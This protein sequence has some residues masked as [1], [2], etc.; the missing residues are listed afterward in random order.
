MTWIILGLLLLLALWV[1]AGLLLLARGSRR[2]GSDYQREVARR[3][4]AVGE[5]VEVALR[6]VAPVR[7][8]LADDHDV[9]LVID[10]SGSMG[11]GPGSPLREAV[12]AAENFIRRLPDN[13]HVGIIGFDHDARLL[14]PLTGEQ[15]QAMRAL[16]SL[17]AGGGTAIHAA[18]KASHAAFQ[19]GRPGIMKTVILLSDGSSASGPAEAEAAHLRQEIER[20]TLV[21]IGF[22]PHVNE[23]LMRSIA[24]AP[25][26]YLHVNNADDLYGLFSFLAGAV[27]GQMAVAGL[28]DEG[29][30]SPSPFK[31][32]RTGGLY[33][34][35]VQPGDPTRNSATRVVWSI[36][37]MNEA[38]VPLTYNLVAECPGWFPVATDDGKATW[39]LPDGTKTEVR[40]PSGPHVLVM[41]RW[42]GW[43]WPILNPLFWIIFGRFWPCAVKPRESQAAAEPEQLPVAALPAL[44][45]AP[46]QRIYE[47]SLR[48]AL[49]I[50]LGE[51]G[52][53][54]VCRLKERLEDRCIDP[55]QVEALAIHVT[56][57]SNRAPVKVGR[58]ALET[59]EIVELHQDL[60]PYLETLRDEGTPP[61]RNWV[62]W[63]SWLAE[64]PPL[65]TLRT[66]ADD[67]R[68]ARLAL[69]RKPDQVETM[70]D[71]GLRRVV[72]QEGVVIVVGSPAD[73]ECSGLLAEVA[74]ICASRD[75]GV[76][77]L[78][79]PTSFFEQPTT[80]MLALA[81]ELERMSLMKGRNLSSDRHQ[82]PV[83]ARQLFDRIVALEEKYDTPAAASVPAAELIWEML[84]YKEV[85]KQLPLLRADGDEVICCSAAVDSH[86]LPA[87]AL[88]R[89]TRER[90]LALGLNGRRLG[91]TQEQGR[92]V[93]PV[94]DKQTVNDDVDDFW[95]G[96]TSLR[97]QPLLLTRLRP[98]LRST[99][100]D[101]ISALLSLQDAVPFDQPYHEQVAYSRQ[102]RQAFAA[103]LEGWCQHI[104]D[105]EQAQ[106]VWGVHVVMPALL[107]VGDELQVVSN[108]INR[109]SGNVDFANLINFASALLVDFSAIVSDLQ[110]EMAQWI[111]KLVGPQLELRVGSPS[112]ATATPLA[113]SIEEERQALE[114]VFD[115]L[116]ARGQE[117]LTQQFQDWYRSY[118]DLILG[119]LSFRAVREANGERV[120]I[121]LSY[122][123]QELDANTDVAETLR[124][125]LDRYRNVVL[126]WPVEQLAQR[127]EVAN[128]LDR[129]RVGKHSALVYPEVLSVADEEDPF[130]ASAVEVRA[131][132]IRQLLGVVPP[133][134]GDAPY[135]WPEEA[136]AARIAQKIRNRL[137]RDPQ[138]FSPIAV[139][140]M[141]DTEKLHGFIND[142]AQGRVV[143]Q[144]TKYV[145]RRDGH[146]YQV[147]PRDE[148]LQGLDAF[149][150]VVQ[151]VVSDEL[152]LDGQTI[153]PA[154]ADL[155]NS[156]AE[157]LK[158][159]EAH[160]LIKPS[161]KSPNWKMWQDL[162]RGLMLEHGGR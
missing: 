55:A 115:S 145:L 109:L 52:E 159:V 114:S 59:D 34:L 156:L 68:K 146:N 123:Q 148:S 77:A 80:E 117:F 151:Q 113:Y 20:L 120:S 98:A 31:L 119:Q 106:G 150:S 67:R 112:D 142:L 94:A 19:I 6:L 79:A 58:T 4:C 57:R 2:L 71:P 28:V 160:P 63:R 10:H 61:L 73:A 33:P 15:R 139:H 25:D 70:L 90:T 21:C 26:K 108:S 136:N 97:P 11:S 125:A 101:S 49:V 111:A 53:W 40:A 122:S 74:H 43:A 29:V 78:F 72:G 30:S 54:T 5:E 91:L 86:S 45:P 118:G 38:P 126:G 143:Q 36:P 138:P 48:P 137:R 24:S 44:P 103:Y 56:H 83:A 37:L 155:T 81:Q 3:V 135:A 23:S 141:R 93:L 124:T 110:R 1:G 152:S 158:A 105:R 116:D 9:L 161:V 64:M 66:I 89:W 7:M 42:F 50:G 130:V 144:G 16:G 121:R 85:F 87:A 60:R 46:Q 47:P 39:R 154:P 100:A 127:K 157:T 147:G 140:L 149:Q 51:V 75:A 14:S 107:R 162:I 65:T 8:P 96:Q 27:S 129:F 84:A 22:G 35:G 76:T 88:W 133:P 92:L 13:I 104:F 134:P 62:P 18:L 12:R 32:T 131:R 69:I 41:P 82:P 95:S 128:P 17:G 132:T 99:N 153:S 102:E